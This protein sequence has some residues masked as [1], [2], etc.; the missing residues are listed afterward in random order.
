MFARACQGSSGQPNHIEALL[1]AA[2]IYIKAIR[3]RAD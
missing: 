2:L 3:C 1:D